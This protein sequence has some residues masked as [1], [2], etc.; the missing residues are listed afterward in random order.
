MR[1]RSHIVFRVF[2]F[3]LAVS[4]WTPG[5]RSEETVAVSNETSLG[6]PVNKLANGLH[7]C[8][9]RHVLNGI[10]HLQRW[11]YTGDWHASD[12]EYFA[13]LDAA[14]AEL[15]KPL[16]VGSVYLPVR[17]IYFYAGVEVNLGPNLRTG[18]GISAALAEV[19]G[20]NPIVQ[21]VAS[22]VVGNRAD[23]L[24]VIRENLRRAFDRVGTA[25]LATI[26]ATGR[27]NV[28]VFGGADRGESVEDEGALYWGLI[29]ESGVGPSGIGKELIFG[30][31]GYV[32]VAS[33]AFLG[34]E[35]A[36]SGGGAYRAWND[37]F[38]EI[39]LYFQVGAKA[40]GNGAATG[41]FVAFDQ[42]QLGEDAIGLLN[43]FSQGEPIQT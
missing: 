20:R 23:M 39:G 40:F 16:R 17:G 7:N 11:W 29:L 4:F 31:D 2:L 21:R 38:Q 36:G 18:A 33:F 27:A 24:E 30:P 1:N 41:A 14:R 26:S 12:R 43:R 9:F 25:T 42:S 13:A 32:D 6:N 15:F 28:I 5:C 10:G 35:K 19:L 3:L 8:C 22:A 34:Y 37:D